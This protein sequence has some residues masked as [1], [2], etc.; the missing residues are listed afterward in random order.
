VETPQRCNA[1][2]AGGTGPKVQRATKFVTDEQMADAR[3]FQ[4]TDATQKMTK[5]REPKG[6]PY[7]S[8]GLILT[9]R[10]LVEIVAEMPHPTTG[11]KLS[12]RNVLN[13][14]LITA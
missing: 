6:D 12:D 14:K 5:I 2:L 1:L 13:S 3:G 7:K 10:L 8:R 9:T 4:Q 11:T